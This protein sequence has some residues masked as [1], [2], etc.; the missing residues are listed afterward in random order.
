MKHVIMAECKG[1][2]GKDIYLAEMRKHM[3]EIARA[4]PKNTVKATRDTPTAEWVC[5]CR[6]TIKK[7]QAAY[8]QAE[9]LQGTTEE[10]WMAVRAV[11]AGVIPRSK[12]AERMEVQER[13]GIERRLGDAIVQA[14]YE[15]MAMLAGR[16]HDM[17]ET[18]TAVEAELAADVELEK[19]V[20]AVER[21][22]EQERTGSKRAQEEAERRAQR[23]EQEAKQRIQ[24]EQAEEARRSTARGGGA[25]A[26]TRRA[27]KQRREWGTAPREGT[28]GK[29]QRKQR[30]KKR[31]KR[32]KQQRGR[33]TGWQR[34]D[35]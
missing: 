7:A 26:D 31:D 35:G 27:A 20:S 33:T 10:E 22:M 19:V 8:A 18:R 24:A 23:E 32:R 21:E 6:L 16:W 4:V 3:K 13:R 28:Q 29:K 2:A 34:D 12:R 1:V 11:L 17:E 9:G 15:V 30:T 5:G 14:Q 25:S